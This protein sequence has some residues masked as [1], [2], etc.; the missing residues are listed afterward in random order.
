MNN[1]KLYAIGTGPGASDLITVRAARLL[2]KLDVLYA[3]AGRKGGDSLALSI[4]REYIGKDVLIKERHFPM[5]NDAQEKQQAWDEVALEIEADVTQ[6]KQVGFITLGDSMLFSTWVFLLERLEN[7]I[8]IDIIP[9]ITSFSCI[10]SQAQFPLCMEQQSLAVMPCTAD[11]EVLRRA[12]IEHEAV[13]LMKVYGR[14]DKVRQLLSEQ[15]LLEHAVL[16]A[17]ASME[18]EIFYPDLSQVREGEA[19]PYF[20]TIV[21][22]RNWKQH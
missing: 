7:K 13:V 15:G 16:M 21:V 6:G 8:D 11:T 17:N 22:N 14:F 4:V 20:S 1:G 5:S 19:L 9:G 10:A 12:L 2:D 18:D 3:P